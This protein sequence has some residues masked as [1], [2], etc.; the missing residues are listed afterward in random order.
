MALLCVQP[1]FISENGSAA[2]CALLEQIDAHGLSLSCAE[3]CAMI[4]TIVARDGDGVVYAQRL[5]VET[6][7]C[8]KNG[9]RIDQTNAHIGSPFGADDPGSG[10]VVPG[11]STIASSLRLRGHGDLVIYGGDQAATA[12]G[13]GKIF[14]SGGQAGSMVHQNISAEI[15]PNLIFGHFYEVTDAPSGVTISLMSLNA[16]VAPAAVIGTLFSAAW[17][18]VCD[19]KT[20]SHVVLA[21]P[22]ECLAAIL[23]VRPVHCE[24]GGLHH[25]C[26]TAQNLAVA[27]PHC[28]GETRIPAPVQDNP[29]PAAPRLVNPMGESVKTIRDQDVLAHTVGA[30]QALA[31]QLESALARI[32]QL[33]TKVAAL[34]AR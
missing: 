34:E 3:V 16:N 33:E 7:A 17:N 14:R 9:S 23:V 31:K 4:N 6:A 5:E 20:K 25:T 29:D 2:L 24:I 19:E 22:E 28:V 30:V 12:Y 13:I 27:I 18:Y 11:L 15:S 21:D 26:F 10:G 8:A 32:D 1:G